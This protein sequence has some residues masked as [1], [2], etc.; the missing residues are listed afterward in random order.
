MVFVNLNLHSLFWIW[1]FF[2]SRHQQVMQ[3]VLHRM[4]YVVHQQLNKENIEKYIKW[5]IINLCLFLYLVEK[6]F[7]VRFYI[8]CLL[9]FIFVMIQNIYRKIF[10]IFHIRSFIE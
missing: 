2:Y 1:T 7:V 9:C 4:L 3:E 5:Q 8:S 6:W 10:L